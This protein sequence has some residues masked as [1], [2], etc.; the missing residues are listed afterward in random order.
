V[1]H[2]VFPPFGFQI[3]YGKSV[4][5]FPLT[6]EVGFDRG[7]QEAF[8]KTARADQEVGFALCCQFPYILSLVNINT[9]EFF[10]FFKILNA[11]GH[12]AGHRIKMRRLFHV[13]SI[14][15][16][17]YGVQPPLTPDFPIFNKSSQK[18]CQIY[19][20][21]HA[22]DPAPVPDRS[23][24]PINKPFAIAFESSD[25][26]ITMEYIRMNIYFTEA[27]VEKKMKKLSFFGSRDT[28]YE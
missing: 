16:Y 5:Q 15:R 23:F 14:E 2:G 26:K 22:G 24:I 11:Y 20:F 27:G 25:A 17:R 12:F 13:F 6:E 21:G 18:I 7:K 19:S 28:R 4:E 9:I 3:R 10:K 1:Q 8:A